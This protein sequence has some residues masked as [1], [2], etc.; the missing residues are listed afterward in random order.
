M[1][2]RK[3][4]MFDKVKIDLRS[5]LLPNMQ[6]PKG[7]VENF[8]EFWATNYFEEKEEL[9]TTTQDQLKP[10]NLQELLREEGLS[11]TIVKVV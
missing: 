7:S 6:Y 2:K 11:G 9:V 5:K 8:Q 3:K 4:N 10:F 1:I